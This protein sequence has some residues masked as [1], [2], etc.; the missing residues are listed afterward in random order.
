[1]KLLFLTTLIVLFY[2]SSD[3]QVFEG[4]WQGIYI[5]SDATFWDSIKLDCKWNPDKSYSIKSYTKGKNMHGKDTIIVCKVEYKII[6]RDSLV[7]Y[8]TEI[9]EPLGTNP[10]ICFQ[11]MELKYQLGHHLQ[12]N[13]VGKWYC[14]PKKNKGGGFLRL[15]KVSL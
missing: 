10:G 2:S 13:L 5:T 8:E 4:T 7:L 3:A 9:L 15:Q 11:T 14:K 6:S 1:M 12:K